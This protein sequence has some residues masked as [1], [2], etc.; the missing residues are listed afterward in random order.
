MRAQ[1]VC[2]AVEDGINVFVAVLGAK[3]LGEFDRL[4]EHDL[5]GNLWMEFELVGAETQ[6]RE[7]DRIYFNQLAI[8]VR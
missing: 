3:G 1:L 5:V 7:F 6:A 8:E 4:V 2:D